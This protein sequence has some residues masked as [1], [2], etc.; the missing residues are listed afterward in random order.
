MPA[1]HIRRAALRKKYIYFMSK[2]YNSGR[3]RNLSASVMAHAQSVLLGETKE[4]RTLASQLADS[5]RHDIIRGE[6][7]P[8][9]KLKLAAL[10]KRYAVGVIP[11]REALSRLVRSGF[12]TAE[13]QRGFRVTGMSVS[14][15][16]D[17][18]RVRLLVEGECLRD[19]MAHGDPAWESRVRDTL[20]RLKSLPMVMSDDERCLLAPDWE[21]A[22][23][24]F[25]Q[26]L[27]SNCESQW[28]LSIAA[29]LREQ[30]AR[31]RHYSVVLRGRNRRNVLKEHAALAD[32]A[33]GRN[34]KTAVT[35]LRA[36]IKRTT[37]LVLAAPD[38]QAAILSTDGCARHVVS[39]PRFACGMPFVGRG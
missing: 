10:S 4:P 14:E 34:A 5:I 29:T 7:P 39:T 37:E 23:E 15:L 24:A 9:A 6:F 3:H 13:D 30:T 19:S 2:I 16:L 28:L 18:T 22:H 1:T 11:L 25:H 26:E 33:L 8:L 12:V 36:H 32:A 35:L 31:Y 21:L 20:I 17:V 38:A 27:L